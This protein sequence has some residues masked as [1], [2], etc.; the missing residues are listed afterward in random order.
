MRILVT[1]G[2]GFIGSH[3]VDACI[4]AGHSVSVVD[5]LWDEGGG[6][7]ANLNPQARFYQLDVRDAA[8]A[9]V[10]DSEKPDVVAHHAAQHSVAISARHPDLDAQVNILGL[11]NL[12]H[13]CVRVG[14]QKVIMASSSTVFGTPRIEPLVESA[15]QMPESPYGITKMASEHYLRYFQAAHGLRYTALRYGNVFG[16]RQDP[17]GEAGVIAIFARRILTGQPVRIDWDGEQA[18]DYVY[19]G[20]VARANM[21]ALT[22]GDNEAYLIGSGA[23]TSVNDLY[24]KL[25]SIIGREVEIVR[26][27]KR[28]GDVRFFTFN[29]AKARADLGWQPEVSLDEGL[30]NTVEYFR[31]MP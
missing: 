18:K 21:A 14:T 23:R 13:N 17:S 3:V 9:A 12:L 7:K 20:D 29:N 25:A 28:A 31:A 22:R 8:L 11:L 16:P 30:H 2:A 10:F 15:L 19:V 4:A 6:K 26:A 24:S 27:P 5:N 1:G